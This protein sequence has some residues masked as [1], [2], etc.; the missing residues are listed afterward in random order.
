MSESWMRREI[1]PTATKK[2]DDRRHREKKV[3]K[4]MKDTCGCVVRCTR[5][6]DKNAHN[7]NQMEWSWRRT[8]R[9]THRK[10]LHRMRK[11]PTTNDCLV[12]F[13]CVINRVR[14]DTRIPY[15]DVCNFAFVFGLAPAP[16]PVQQ[17]APEFTHRAMKT[18][19]A[20]TSAINAKISCQT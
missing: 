9:E 16:T 8:G 12:L 2:R 15:F 17:S 7:D 13:M 5:A 3:N 18:T 11:M 10:S 6:N 20:L 4:W 1:P 14:T 19:I